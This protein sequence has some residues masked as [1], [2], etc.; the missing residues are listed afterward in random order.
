[1]D[2][3]PSSLRY[4]ASKI[5]MR[6]NN[7][8]VRPSGT[9]SGTENSIF[10]VVLPERSLVELSSLQLI[11]D[12]SFTNLVAGAN[13]LNVKMPSV[14]KLIRSVRVYVGGQLVSGNSAHY[15]IL[16]HALLKCTA[17]EDYVLSRIESSFQDHL[18]KADE[19]SDFDVDN[20]ATSKSM[21]Y[22][23]TDLLGLFRSGEQTIIDTS[24]WG[25][26]EIEFTMNSLA[27]VQR[28]KGGN[29]SANADNVKVAY[30][31]LHCRVNCITQISPLYNEVLNVRLNDKSMPLRLPYMNFITNILTGNNKCSIEVNSAC[32][33]SILFAPLPSTYDTN[34]TYAAANNPDNA[35]ANRY[36][37]NSGRTLANANNCS[38]YAQVGSEQWPRSAF[39]NALDVAPATTQAFWGESSDSRSLLY[40]SITTTAS[41][42]P[43][44]Q[45]YSRLI[46]LENNF[47]W[48][49]P[50]SSSK[51]G[52][53]T[54]VLSG[55]DTAN[56]SIQMS[57]NQTNL[58]PNNGFAFVA[59]LTTSMLVYNT[60]SQSV[61]VI[62]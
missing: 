32:V 59:A 25:N 35:H 20:A 47:I 53:R 44:V 23:H 50:F 4:N 11:F 17:S 8:L 60:D 57:I 6:T 42:T 14:Y 30:S 2:K 9:D 62:L 28:K 38:L 1:M 29:D 41:G 18:G 52:Y 55:L 7:F 58:I 54:K 19:A 51:E 49:Q 24:L 46:F 12:A 27:G 31:N 56:Q 39:T 40:Q 48:V 21:H 45:Q 15:D 26:I 33:D 34:T 13:F 16:Y 36:K 61:S 22:V 37:F 43:A 5:M 10:R 3:I